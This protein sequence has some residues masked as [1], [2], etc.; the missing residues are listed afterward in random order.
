M[1]EKIIKILLAFTLGLLIMST[2][3]NVASADEDSNE[4]EDEVLNEDVEA[5]EYVDE[6]VDE[7]D[8]DIETSTEVDETDDEIEDTETLAVETDDETGATIPQASIEAMRDFIENNSAENP[9]II[10]TGLAFNDAINALD[11]G[12]GITVWTPMSGFGTG[13]ACG[14]MTLQLNRQESE[15]EESF[16]DEY[17]FWEICIFYEPEAPNSS[18]TIPQSSIEAMRDFIENNSAENPLIIPAGLDFNEA[19]NAL[20]WGEGITVWTP[21]SGLGSPQVCGS[22]ALQLNRQESEEGEET[23]DDEYGF[24]DICLYYEFEDQP[25]SSSSSPSTEPISSPSSPSSE[26]TSEPTEPARRPNLPQTGVTL[27][28]SSLIGVSVLAVCGLVVY[29]RKKNKD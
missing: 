13:S 18:P 15:E 14:A 4:V 7:D 12:E 10:P 24:W 2:A 16:D 5:P 27:L 1:L 29:L 11:W 20:D 26:P 6:L 28:N 17:G 8:E 23:Y 3:T 9:L 25:E 19:I 22:L 21:M